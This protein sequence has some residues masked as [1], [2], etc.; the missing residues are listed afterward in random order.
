MTENTIHFGFSANGLPNKPPAIYII[1]L[2]YYINN[3]NI[4]NLWNNIY[5][6]DNIYKYYDCTLIIYSIMSIFRHPS[7]VSMTYF[8]HMR[9]SLY[10]SW[11]FGCASILA[12][13]HSI[14]PDIFITSSTDALSNI[15]KLIKIRMQYNNIEL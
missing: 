13:I 3:I 2:Y 1:L 15:S 7:N 8:E 11:K 6:L 4:N 10:L 12:I 9:F 5:N 14:Y